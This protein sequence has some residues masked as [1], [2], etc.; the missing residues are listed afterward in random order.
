MTKNIS[1]I[2]PELVTWLQGLQ[3]FLETNPSE[4]LY[5][6]GYSGTKCG[7]VALEVTKIIN[8]YLALCRAMNR[9]TTTIV[10]VQDGKQY[11]M[12]EAVKYT[13]SIL[14]NELCLQGSPVRQTIA[15]GYY[16][17]GTQVGVTH[18]DLD[19]LLAIFEMV[20]RSQIQIICNRYIAIG[21]KDHLPVKWLALC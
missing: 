18:V 21:N 10:D 17:L 14:E 1:I 12:S 15:T 19:F 7:G 3:N 9:G 2:K 20:I 16:S 4:N 5:E 8:S 6:K 11:K 13:E